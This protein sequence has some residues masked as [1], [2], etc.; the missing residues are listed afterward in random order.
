MI[1]KEQ[2][3]DARQIVAEY[4]NQEYAAALERAKREWPI[5]T[6]AESQDG[7]SSGIIYGYGRAGNNVTL[8]VRTVGVKRS[9]GHF[10]AKY[11]RKIE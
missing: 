1:T 7:W 3:D 10:L 5:G 9:A 4:E 6:K 8:K 2:Y 11:A